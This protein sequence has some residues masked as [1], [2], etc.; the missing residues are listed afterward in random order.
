MRGVVCVCVGPYAL[1]IY[2]EVF[3]GKII[4][5]LWFAFY[6]FR[7]TKGGRDRWNKIGTTLL[8]VEAGYIIHKVHCSISP[9]HI[10][11]NFHNKVFKIENHI[12]NFRL[13]LVNDNV[14]PTNKNLWEITKTLI[15]RKLITLMC[16]D[17]LDWA[18]SVCLVY[19]A[20]PIPTVPVM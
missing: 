7:K 13:L 17:N 14:M 9:L 4:W 8:S 10:Y 11:E 20:V 5:C 18:T 19:H 3:K 6:K 12:W 15:G 1:E 16:S 2:S